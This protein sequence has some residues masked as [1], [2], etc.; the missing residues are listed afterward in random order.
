MTMDD[1]V[2]MKWTPKGQNIRKWLFTK[3][4]EAEKENVC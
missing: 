3:A 2:V 1:L 4:S